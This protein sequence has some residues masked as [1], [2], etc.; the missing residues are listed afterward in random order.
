MGIRT[1]NSQELT[2]LSIADA[3]RETGFSSGTAVGPV[4][5]AARLE[6]NDPPTT[7][8]R[9]NSIGFLINSDG[10]WLQVGTPEADLCIAQTGR[11]PTMASA[12]ET[13]GFIAIEYA[14]S[15]IRVMLNPASVAHLAVASL[16]PRLAVVELPVEL[17]FPAVGRLSERSPSGAVAMQ[18]IEALVT[19][20]R[21]VAL[22]R[23]AQALPLIGRHPLSTL[24]ISAGLYVISASGE[25]F[26]QD[27][28]RLKAEIGFSDPTVDAIGYAVRNMGFIKF[29]ISD[30]GLVTVALHPR[31]AE[32]A[33]AKSVAQRL[34]RMDGRRFEIRYFE[35]Q[36]KSE[37]FPTGAAAAAKIKDLC[38][39]ASEPQNRARWNLMTVTP[40]E[41]S[42]A[43]NDPL[44]LMHQKWRVSFGNFGESVFAFAMRHGLLGRIILAGARRAEDD[45]VFRYIGDEFGTYMTEEFRFKA[46]GNSVLQQ[47]DR[48]YGEWVNAAYKSVALAGTPRLDYIDVNLPVSKRGPWIR[49]ERLLLPWKMPNGGVLVSMSSRITADQMLKPPSA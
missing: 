47:P 35:D 49:Y 38:G 9:A 20:H 12:V 3:C 13:N 25:W 31:N 48:D 44:L 40:A 21:D 16:R 26:S 15:G 14:R 42:K 34:E 24:A 37:A 2:V 45:L 17:T 43:G 28:Q 39:I 7:D 4:V 46:I 18:R 19:L 23:F 11:A 33:A 8:G 27:D 1:R 22:E 36:W 30:P 32:A 10:T 6:R 29:S 41:L 5:L